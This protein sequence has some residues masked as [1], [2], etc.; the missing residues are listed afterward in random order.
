MKENK[1][2]VFSPW[3]IYAQ[4]VNAIFGA[5]PAIKI[6]FDDEL[7]KLKLYVDGQEKADAIGKLLPVQKQ[8]GNITL[9]IEVIPSN[10]DRNTV[11]IFNDAFKG[12]PVFSYAMK[13]G[14]PGMFQDTNFVVFKNFVT[15]YKS[16]NLFDI[17][18][19]TSCLLQ[20]IVGEVFD[21]LDDDVRY[22]TDLPDNRN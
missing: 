21:E 17:N 5:D 18:G 10:R 2:G 11:D 4:Q 22:C 9:D 7:K 13:P 8:F 6:E 14:N 3:V 15:Q 19:V 12:N 16:D 20:D 1:L